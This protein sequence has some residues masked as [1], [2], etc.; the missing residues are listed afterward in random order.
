MVDRQIRFSTGEASIVLDGPNITMSAQ[1]NIVL[2]ATDHVS[3]LSE[4]EIAI[5]ARH[6][7]AMVSATG[8]VILQARGNL[9]LNPYP[10]GGPLREIQ[11][12]EPPVPQPVDPAKCAHCGGSITIAENGARSCA[13]MEGELPAGRIAALGTDATFED[14]EA[15]N[16]AS[17]AEDSRVL[18]V[19]VARHGLSNDLLEHVVK[20]AADTLDG[21]SPSYDRVLAWLLEQRQITREEHAEL[22]ELPAL[23]EAPAFVGV[24]LRW[25]ACNAAAAVGA[26]WT[27]VGGDLRRME[28]LDQGR[29]TMSVYLP[30]EVHVVFHD[31]MVLKALVGLVQTRTPPATPD[32]AQEETRRDE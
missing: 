12:L 1:G 30:H 5:G 11:R 29:V 22:R 10:E 2:H 21:V 31:Q 19:E 6:T 27:F 20:L 3:I 15:S 23:A 13:A 4:K 8:D 24:V 28:P 16:G 9:H 25:W 14:E 7:A 17:F 32:E 26:R 18:T